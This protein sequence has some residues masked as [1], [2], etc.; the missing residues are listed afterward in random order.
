[1]A[2]VR[3]Q[4]G[5]KEEVDLESPPSIVVQETSGLGGSTYTEVTSSSAALPLS[6]SIVNER[7]YKPR[8]Q[9]AI[10]LL[11]KVYREHGYQGWYQVSS[12]RRSSVRCTMLKDCS[13]APRACLHKLPRQFSPKHFCSCS[14]I[15]SNATHSSLSFSSGDSRCD[16][17]R[18]VLMDTC[19]K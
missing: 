11:R 4:A 14:R 12:N 19:T 8:K 6:G 7:K 15:S 17:R 9:S 3:L 18:S 16:I 10:E 5:P 2:K 13:R 1:M